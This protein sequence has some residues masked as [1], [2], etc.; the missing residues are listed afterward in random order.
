MQVGHVGE[1][2]LDRNI[3][4]MGQGDEIGLGR[5]RV[6]AQKHRDAG[7]PGQGGMGRKPRLM[8][9]HDLRHAGLAGDRRSLCVGVRSGVCPQAKGDRLPDFL[10]CFDR[11]GARQRQRAAIGLERG[12]RPVAL[13]FHL[14]DLAREVERDGDRA[15]LVGK[16]PDVAGGLAGGDLGGKGGFRLAAVGVADDHTALRRHRLMG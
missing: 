5:L 1:N 6:K 14:E 8:G 4:A 12:I 9:Q 13:I 11:E 7:K 16:L 3:A 15:D 10:A 2:D